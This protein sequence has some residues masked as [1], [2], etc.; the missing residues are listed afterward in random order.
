MEVLNEIVGKNLKIYQDSEYFKFSLDSVLLPGFV[1]IKLRDKRILD[2]CSGNAP[3]PLILSLKTKIEIYGVELQ[4]EIYD[5]A[6]KSVKINHKEEQIKILN[7]DVRN[8]KDLFQG[9]FF[10]IITTNP[11]YFKT[12]K[13]SKTSK[14]QVL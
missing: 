3:I 4:K 11:P 2:L 1:N 13:E 9:D 10:D 5:L 8:L 7:Y 12:Y 14:N 6:L